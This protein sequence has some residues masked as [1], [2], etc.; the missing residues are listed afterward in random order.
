MRNTFTNQNT[1]FIYYSLFC[2]CFFLVQ[3]SFLQL[4]R[5]VPFLLFLS[6]TVSCICSVIRSIQY[7][8]Q[9]ILRCTHQTSVPCDA[10]ALHLQYSRKACVCSCSPIQNG[11]L[12]PTAAFRGLTLSV[13]CPFNIRNEYKRKNNNCDE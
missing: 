1:V 12:M 3:T 11:T 4:I 13:I 10:T 9:A 6:E 7:H 5:A 2:Q 8:I